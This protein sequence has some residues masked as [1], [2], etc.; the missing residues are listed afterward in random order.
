MISIRPTE[1]LPLRQGEEMAIIQLAV[2]DD[3]EME[4][5]ETFY[6]H[7]DAPTGTVLHDTLSRMEVLINSPL[8]K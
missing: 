5:D 8:K 2:P 3:Y 1:P 4:T 7:L 6:V